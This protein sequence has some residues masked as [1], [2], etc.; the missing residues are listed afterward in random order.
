MLLPL[1][2]HQTSE[3]TAQVC[4]SSGMHGPDATCLLG[5]HGSVLSRGGHRHCKKCARAVHLSAQQ[6]AAPHVLLTKVS[7]EKW[8]GL[9]R[10][11]YSAW[12]GPASSSTP[13]WMPSICVVHYS[14]QGSHFPLYLGENK[15]LKNLCGLSKV[16]RHFGD[17]TQCQLHREEVSQPRNVVVTAGCIGGASLGRPGGV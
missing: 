17:K 11:R 13:Q 3:S 8:L 12:Q 2:F 1:G 16:T 10:S 15:S 6:V 5:L 4:W 7:A 14:L 9:T